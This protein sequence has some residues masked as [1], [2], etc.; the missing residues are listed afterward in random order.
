M[1]RAHPPELREAAIETARQQGVTAAAKA[2]GVGKGTISRWCS[3][4][5]VATVPNEQTAAM[6]EAARLKREAARETLKG[7]LLDKALDML[8][9][10]DEEHKDYRGKDADAVYWDKA[11]ASACQQFATA[12]AILI[13][14]SQ[15]LDGQATHRHDLTGK[16]GEVL[17]DAHDAGLRLVGS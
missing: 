6:V 5:G 7:K 17:A 13:D 8:G 9:R 16:R 14:K 2:H 11:P 15:L 1:P 12:A 10:M 3:E 4:Q